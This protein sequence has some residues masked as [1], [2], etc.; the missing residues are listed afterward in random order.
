MRK[1]KGFTLVEIMIVVAIIALLAAITIP[2][3]LKP[4][5]TARNSAAKGELRT[6]ATAIE[7]YAIDNNAVYPTDL[8][9]LATDY[10]P[11]VPCTTT[12]TNGTKGGFTYFCDS[13][14]VGSYNIV[15][16]P[17]S[18]GTSGTKAYNLTSGGQID[19]MDCESGACY[20]H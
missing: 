7:N 16:V 8:D 10:I 12:G 18:K 11:A 3:L 5:Q 15:A 6:L 4:Q 2:N 9:D 19:E 17:T 1:S 13:V 20:G 14:A